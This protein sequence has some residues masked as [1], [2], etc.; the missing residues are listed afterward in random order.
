[1]SLFRRYIAKNF[2]LKV[3]S[4]LM[5]V[6]LWAAITRDQTVEDAFNVPIEFHAIPENLELNSETIP[7]AQVRVRGPSRVL[8]SLRTGD[9]H[10]DVDL[11]GALPG[12]RTY[13]LNA[14]RVVHVPRNVTVSQVIPGQLQVNFDWRST[15]K[16][17]VRPRLVGT[18]A[19]GLTISGVTPK[20]AEITITG[21]RQ[22]VNAVSAA[23]TDAIDVSSLTRRR[24]Y[25]TNAFVTDPLV[26]VV[27]P[28]EVNVTVDVSRNSPAH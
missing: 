24:A 22:R 11:T 25:M 2:G 28:V 1:M 20:P 10:V 8:A 18:P 6:L 26:Q 4:L 9:I 23:I 13:D 17:P 12:E 7:Q 15:R 14:Q 19:S 3:F 27:R 16:V 5:A 21:P